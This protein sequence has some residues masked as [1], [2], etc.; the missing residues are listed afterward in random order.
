MTDKKIPASAPAGPFVVIHFQTHFGGRI[1]W[2]TALAV[3]PGEDLE[4]AL[5]RLPAELSREMHEKYLDPPY[6]RVAVAVDGALV[7]RGQ[8]GQTRL[9]GGERVA[10][11]ALLVGG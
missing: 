6:P 4:A 5:H 10:I 11:F 1:N 8:I 7:P 3:P 2:E 9:Q